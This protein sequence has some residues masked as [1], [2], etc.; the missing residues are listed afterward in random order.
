MMSPNL[1]LIIVPLIRR[2]E[3]PIFSRRSFW[4]TCEGDVGRGSHSAEIEEGRS[5]VLQNH[6]T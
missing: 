1:Y 3:Q 5:R 6:G 2:N 4:S